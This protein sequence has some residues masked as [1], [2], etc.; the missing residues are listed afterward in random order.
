MIEGSPVIDIKP[1]IPEF[2]S[3]DKVRIG[4]LEGKV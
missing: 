3:D 4:W 1:Y 2:K